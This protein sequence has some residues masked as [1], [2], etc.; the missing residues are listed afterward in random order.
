LIKKRG[1]RVIAHA[2]YKGVP[3]ISDSIILR[4]YKNTLVL[5]LED[6]QMIAALKDSPWILKISSNTSI[7]GT[8]AFFDKEKKYLFLKN[9]HKINEDYHLRKTIRYQPEDI[10]NITVEIESK[11]LTLGL[12]DINEYAFRA[13][14]N[15][16][17]IIDKIANYDKSIPTKIVLDEKEVQ[18][19]STYLF[20]AG[21]CD[22]EAAIVMN[23]TSDET[24]IS[25][26]QNWRNN[27]QLE[28]IK[29]VHKS[30][31]DIL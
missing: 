6:K 28:I 23:Y 1:G 11:K 14:S 5:K 30:T 27:R 15:N 7:K 2:L 4:A 26:L 17:V 25:M 21:R 24:G 22:G 29:E 9:L 16:Q 31:Q 19:K 3:L 12:V 8:V 20:E 13:L 10:V 18:L